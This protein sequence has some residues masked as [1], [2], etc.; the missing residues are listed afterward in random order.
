MGRRLD[1]GL[2]ARIGIVDA[3]CTE[4]EFDFPLVDSRI[5]GVFPRL[6]YIRGVCCFVAVVVVGERCLVT[7]VRVSDLVSV[8]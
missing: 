4:A 5:R 7:L 8:E 2:L 6:Y 1:S 3:I